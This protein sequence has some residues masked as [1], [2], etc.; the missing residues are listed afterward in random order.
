MSAMHRDWRRTVRDVKSL[1][2]RALKVEERDPVEAEIFRY[3]AAHKALL[4]CQVAPGPLNVARLA[5]AT[6]LGRR[7][8]PPN[9]F[10]E[11]N[12][13]GDAKPE[14]FLEIFKSLTCSEWAR[15]QLFFID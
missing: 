8:C 1:L 2:A 11:K 4:L 12:G 7:R 10:G 14:K 15:C 13:V 5:L 9:L 3:F 6:P